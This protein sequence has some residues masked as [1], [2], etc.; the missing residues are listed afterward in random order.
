MK[1]LT[2]EE[3]KLKLSQINKEFELVEEYK[4]KTTLKHKLLHKKCG[5]VI[6]KTLGKM[7]CNNPEY[8][9]ICSGKNKHKTTETYIEE[10]NA[11]Y[12]E[13]VIEILGQYI[14]AKTPIPIHR[15]DCEH[16][17]NVAP[18]NL[19][20]KKGCPK[21]GIRQ[22]KYMDKVEE[23]LISIQE[24]YEK[25]KR[26]EECKNVRPLP[27]DY[28][29]PNK[30][31]LIEVDGEFHYV[32]GRFKSAEARLESVKRRDQIKTEYC[33]NNNIPL[34]RLPYF[35]FENFEKIIKEFLYVNTEVTTKSK[36]FVAP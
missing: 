27:F 18:T 16:D 26:I 34:L 15:N 2:T 35:E 32:Q 19:L 11:I 24:P 8:C 23:I 36:E 4:G 20:R 17:Y 22:S 29:L 1:K 31:I 12:G 25:E 30:N 13:G 7:I 9:Y 5:N 3:V 6:E 14:D 33:K 10:I 21:C 28:Y